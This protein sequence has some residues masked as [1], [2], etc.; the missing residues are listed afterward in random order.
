MILLALL[1]CL[2]YADGMAQV[3][4]LSCE[5]ADVCGQPLYGF[6]S[7]AACQEAAAAQP[8]EECAG[9]SEDAMRACIDAYE[10][11]VADVACDEATDEAL[12][13]ACVVCGG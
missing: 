7:V 8:Y 9:Y 3:G 5:R 4:A 6:D 12:A 2:S 1:G 10:T 13:S 11:A